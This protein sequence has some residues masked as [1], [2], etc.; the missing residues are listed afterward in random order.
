MHAQ[1]AVR[2]AQ[3]RR[4]AVSGQM[5]KKGAPNKTVL[6]LLL[7]HMPVRIS[8]R[9]TAAGGHKPDC[10]ADHA[11]DHKSEHSAHLPL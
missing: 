1:F 7:I 6:L 4:Y 8:R 5:L 9:G 11:P 2:N 3:S 10:S